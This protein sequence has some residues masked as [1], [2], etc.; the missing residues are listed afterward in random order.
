VSQSATRVLAVS[1][2][3]DDAAFSCGATLARLAREG[4]EV[5]VVTVFTASVEAPTG[6]ALACQTDKGLAADV[7]YLALRR[8]E[9][10]AALA[11]LGARGVHL[12]HREAPHRGYDSAAALFAGV[13]PDDTVATPVAADLAALAAELRSQLVLAPQGRGAHVDHLQ[14]LNAVRSAGLAPVCW[15][16]DTPYVLR[17]PDAPTAEALPDGL[18]ALVVELAPADL[19]ALCAAACAYTSQLG[20]QFGGAAETAA[21]LRA[22]ATAQGRR[23]GSAGPVE[24][25]LAPPNYGRTLA[26]HLPG[27]TASPL[28]SPAPSGPA[29]ATALRTIS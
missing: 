21:A 12:G 8:A 9:D 26:G 15:Y 2:H 16:A 5:T 7:D 25:L 13:R 28:A 19:D 6:F 18:A 23:H 22:H 10:D 20:F 29:G 17:D 27:V 11:A 14:V 4:H 24:V 3:L 1:P